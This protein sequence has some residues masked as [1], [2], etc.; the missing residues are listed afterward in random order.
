ML[1]LRTSPVLDAA[2]RTAY[3]LG[4]PLARFWWRLTRPRHLGAVVAIYVG[5]ALLLVRCSYRRGWH[6]PGGGIR[7]GETPK[8]AA[9][10]ELAEEL[11]LVAPALSSR[12]LNIGEHV[13]AIAHPGSTSFR[14]L[15]LV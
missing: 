11:G 12:R 8:D 7:S 9:L 15:C 6:L 5:A 4:F 10:R 3:Y 2:W 13:R 14:N 1:D